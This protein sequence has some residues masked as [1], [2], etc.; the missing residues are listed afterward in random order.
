MPSLLSFNRLWAS[1][2]STLWVHLPFRPL[3]HHQPRC[4]HSLLIVNGNSSVS[5]SIRSNH[6]FVPRNVL[7]QYIES[8]VYGLSEVRG[9][10]FVEDPSLTYL[11]SLNACRKHQLNASKACDAIV[12]TL[13]PK[14]YELI[15]NI[16]PGNAYAVMMK[17]RRTY[18]LE[19]SS[20]THGARL[21]KLGDNIKT[22]SESIADCI[23]RTERILYDLRQQDETEMSAKMKK[24]YILHGLRKDDTWSG[25]AGFIRRLDTHREWSYDEVIQHLTNEEYT[26]NKA[27]TTSSSS[28]TSSSQPPQTE[29]HA[30]SSSSRGSHQ[31][32]GRGRG[33]GRNHHN[34]HYQDNA[35]HHQSSHRGHGHNRGHGSQRGRRHTRDN[36]GSSSNAVRCYNCNGVGHTSNDCPSQHVGLRC[37][38]CG[39]TGH[40]SSQCN[41]NKRSS[42]DNTNDN[43][44]KRMK[45]SS[46]CVIT[47]LSPSDTA[48]SQALH[49]HSN[50]NNTSAWIL[51][52]GASDHC[53]SNLDLLTDVRTLSPP[54]YIKT[55][56]GMST[57]TSKG[58]A[59]IQISPDHTLTLHDVL[60]VPD[61]HVNLLSVYKIACAGANVLYKRDAAYVMKNNIIDITINRQN[62]IYVLHSTNPSSSSQ[63]LLSP[64]L[65]SATRP[66][67]E[68]MS[69][70]YTSVYGSDGKS[71]VAAATSTTSTHDQ[72]LINELKNIHYK[73]GH[74]NHQRLIKM[75]THHTIDFPSKLTISSQK[76]LLKTL[77]NDPCEGCL[78]GKMT[79]KSMIGTVNYNI[80][81][82]MDLWVFDTMIFKIKTLNGECNFTMHIDIKSTEII[83]ALHTQKSDI[84]TYS[85]QLIK[86][87]QRQT[88][89][90]LKHIHSD[91]GSEICTNAFADF[92]TEEG[93]LHTTTIPNTPQHN[94]IVE[95]KGRSIID[96]TSAMMHH[97]KAWLPLYGECIMT[98]VYIE[99]R[100]TNT[101]TEFMTPW[102]WTSHWSQTYCQV[103]SRVGMWCF[104]PQSQ[105]LPWKQT[106][107]Q[108]Q[109][110]HICWLRSVQRN[111]LS[112]II[113]WQSDGDSWTWCY[114]LW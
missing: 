65:T 108:E 106:V 32:R 87:C 17:L 76:K 71:M 79:R 100:T 104:L 58:T 26:L 77:M 97:A 42:D 61:F 83:G 37:F 6:T 60:Y 24:H 45:H 51:D 75:I 86:Q 25:V 114:I 85:I 99:N 91:G 56:N 98:A 70:T 93:I 29:S 46:Y 64:T 66:P 67:A 94:S 47:S 53:A 36:D 43:N 107:S 74:T 28:S 5:I 52:G 102:H 23:A 14:Q 39:R 18:G 69:E 89:K 111:I 16:T 9:T 10:P 112:N 95:R 103:F 27:T 33:R 48:L 84:D 7:L 2:A 109:A 49:T 96:K 68:K 12:Q 81:N 59:T 38:T 55:A 113:A 20:N 22:S 31:K 35:R 1:I 101:R 41:K 54:H 11:G 80:N 62:N 8:P 105:N 50:I 90:K 92:C 110:G 13:R 78:L 73:H 44:N 40:T 82:I 57:C 72:Q 4:H 88:R 15:N 19:Q 3:N 63:W 34:A 21:E 30:L